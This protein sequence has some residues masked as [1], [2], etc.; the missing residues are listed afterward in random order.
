M[1]LPRP[2]YEA[3]PWAS[4]LVGLA[5]FAVAWWVERSPRSALFAL[6]A[7]LV[8]IGTLLVMK[9]RDYRSTQSDYDPRAIDE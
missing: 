4:I 7:G 1:W 8:T 5:C 6:G 3:K 2:L 9:R